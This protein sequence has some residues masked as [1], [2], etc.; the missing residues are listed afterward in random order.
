MYGKINIIYNQDAAKAANPTYNAIC[1][2]NSSGEYETLLLTENDLKVTRAR[3][4]KNPEDC[5][6][7]S[8]LARAI[9]WSLRVLRVL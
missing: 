1:V 2:L 5:I 4:A 9:L 7:V 8:W 3:A 6:K